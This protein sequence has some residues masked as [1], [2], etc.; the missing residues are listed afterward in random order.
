MKKREFDIVLWGATGF[1]GQLVAKYLNTQYGSQG[2][3]KW[4]IAGRNEEKLKSL[5]SKLGIEELTIITADSNDE[6][7]LSKMTSRCSVICTTV[8]PYSLYG[9]K[10]VK[11][12][13]ENGTDYCDLTGEV[14]WIKRM[15]DEHHKAAKVNDVK[16]VHTCGFDSIPSDMGVYH[17]QKVAH[18]RFGHFCSHVKFRLRAAKGG[19]SGGTYASMVNVVSEAEKDKTIYE[20]LFH[21]YGLNPP[22]QMKGP[23]RKDLT[24][25]VYDRDAGSWISPFLMAAINT[26]VVRRSHALAGFP[27]GENFR[28]DEAVLTGSGLSGRLKGLMALA[29]TGLMMAAKPDSIPGK[30]MNLFL[31][32]PGEGP[33]EKL[34]ESGFYKILFIGITPDGKTIRTTV[35]GDKDPGYGST[36]KMLAESAVCLA[37]DRSD[38]P[39]GGGVLTPSTAMGDSLLKRLQDNAGL[40]FKLKE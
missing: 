1:T 12:C 33:S 36:S 15:I 24:K 31:P 11:S 6:E 3:L 16:I 7:S 37:M 28:Y 9:S 10:L 23:D 20:T 17:L 14:Q 29:G 40:T 38:L 5:R 18:E 8:G 4:A 13:V 35:T 26:K 21:P 19:I 22:D 34:R 27:Y 2:P 25:V 30:I 32:K 39:K